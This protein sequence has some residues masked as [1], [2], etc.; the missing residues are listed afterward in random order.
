MS[1]IRAGA[2]IIHKS[3]VIL[4]KRV[5]K[6]KTY[7]VFIGGSV[8]DNETVEQAVLRETTEETS[9]QISIKK[10]LYHQF[11]PK[12]DEHFYYLCEYI[13]GTPQLG[14]ANELKT[15]QHNPLDIYKPMWFDL[16]NLPRS[17]IYPQEIL[18]ELLKDFKQNFKNNPKKI[19]NR[20]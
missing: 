19:I 18:K 7:Y 9:L 5:R 12:G 2:I 16:N 15:M 14:D 17:P 6:G 4:M 13:S 8:N 3:Q 10:L 20:I 1:R 11:Y